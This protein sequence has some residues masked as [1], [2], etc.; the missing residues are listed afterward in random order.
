MTATLDKVKAQ[1]F[2]QTDIVTMTV[3]ATE[4]KM[5]RR[6]IDVEAIAAAI[7]KPVD[8][9]G[10][11]LRQLKLMGRET[12]T[13]HY[14]TFVE[15]A[16]SEVFEAIPPEKQRKLAMRHGYE[17]LKGQLFPRPAAAAVAAPTNQM[18]LGDDEE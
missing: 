5:A 10:V 8:L 6:E 9:T 14:R 7:G 15:K 17:V 3:L 4:A 18:A 2:P 16:L 12:L 11:K 1:R 13:E